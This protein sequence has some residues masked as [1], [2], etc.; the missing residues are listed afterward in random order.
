MPARWTR[1]STAAASTGLES[2]VAHVGV[3]VPE[4]GAREVRPV[5]ACGR[6]VHLDDAHPRVIE[7]ILQPVGVDSDDLRVRPLGVTLV[8]S[9]AAREPFMP[10]TSVSTDLLDVDPAQ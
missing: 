6:H 9:N 3:D 7:V 4:H 2:R 8:V 1:L 5:V 10:T